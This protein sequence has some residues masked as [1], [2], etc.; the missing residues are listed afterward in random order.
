MSDQPQTEHI[1]TTFGREYPVDSSSV[2]FPGEYYN[3]TYGLLQSWY[4]EKQVGIDQENNGIGG[5]PWT[6]SGAFTDNK[7]ITWNSE[8]LAVIG[9]TEFL[10]NLGQHMLKLLEAIGAKPTDEALRALDVQINGLKGVV[11]LKIDVPPPYKGQQ[12]E[13]HKS[14]LL[15]HL[16][17][18]Q[19]LAQAACVEY[20]I[21]SCQISDAILVNALAAIVTM[22]R[23]HIRWNEELYIES[24]T[25]CPI[26]VPWV[27]DFGPHGVGRWDK[28]GSNPNILEVPPGSRNQES[29]ESAESAEIKK[30]APK[31]ARKP[32]TNVSVPQLV[33]EKPRQD[34]SEIVADDFPVG[35]PVGQAPIPG[36]VLPG[37]YTEQFP[38]ENGYNAPRAKVQRLI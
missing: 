36:G 1:L 26:A 16:D 14:T 8:F 11:F 10:Q 33:A 17:K 31:A 22:Q 7:L 9:L 24:S 32:T 30:K 25:N 19:T 13:A 12:T 38:E 37:G 28:I 29:A 27:G 5:K 3:A 21:L 2:G 15:E 34:L 20:K 35:F 6:R 18:F 23:V 4:S